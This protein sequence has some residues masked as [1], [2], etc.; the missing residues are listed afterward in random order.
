[1]G[2]LD[3]IDAEY[4]MTDPR[5]DWAVKSAVTSQDDPACDITTTNASKSENVRPSTHPILS[6]DNNNNHKNQTRTTPQNHE[7]AQRQRTI[8]SF[9]GGEDPDEDEIDNYRADKRPAVPILEQYKEWRTH[10]G[11]NVPAYWAD[12]RQ[13]KFRA[14]PRG[15]NISDSEED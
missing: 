2:R 9:N 8:V 11:P 4:A 10:N 7:Q 3:V 6:D 1:M 13:P 12:T 14:T 5:N 15:L